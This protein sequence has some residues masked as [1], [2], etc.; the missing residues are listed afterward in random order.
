MRQGE[1]V[2]LR[3]GALAQDEVQLVVLHGRIQGFLDRGV[4]PVNLVHEENVPLAK[5]AQDGGQVL[6]SFQHRTGGGENVYTQ[7]GGNDVGQCRLS[8]TGRAGE[9]D[10]VESLVARPR[11]LDEDVEV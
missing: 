9:E 4:E 2:R 6:W 10:V 7:L 8:K 1:L 5:V 3:G 11:A